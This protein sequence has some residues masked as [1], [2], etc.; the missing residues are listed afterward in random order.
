MDRSKSGNPDDVALIGDLAAVVLR[1]LPWQWVLF[2]KGLHVFQQH[3]GS[4][5]SSRISSGGALE[6]FFSAA[7]LDMSSVDWRRRLAGVV[8]TGEPV[9]M[10]HIGSTRREKEPRIFNLSCIAIKD[11]D[12]RTIGGLLIVEDM[13]DRTVLE[14]R[15]AFYERLA[16]V[17]KLAAGSPTSS[18][19][20]STAS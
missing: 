3:V 1:H 5:S 4:D 15:V 6:D 8:E 10:E 13:T 14:K 11:D 19:T 12:G 16:V 20:P 17:G 18:I 9:R 2:D 7:A